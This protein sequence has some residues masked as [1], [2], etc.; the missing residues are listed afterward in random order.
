MQS[1][2]IDTR[3]S[4]WFTRRRKALVPVLSSIQR[5]KDLPRGQISIHLNICHRHCHELTEAFIQR[6]QKEIVLLGH[7]YRLQSENKTEFE[8]KALYSRIIS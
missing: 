5:L 4:F 6:D 3:M 1:P 8:F 7:V 2:F